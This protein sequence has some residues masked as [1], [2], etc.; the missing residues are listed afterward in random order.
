MHTY[1]YVQTVGE[2]DI[3]QSC[4]HCS[5]VS[6]WGRKS[7]HKILFKLLLLFLR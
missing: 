1:I 3:F 7:E 5:F 6:E 4:G 2:N